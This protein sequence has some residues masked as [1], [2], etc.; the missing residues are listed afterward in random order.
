[1]RSGWIVQ[2]TRA[3]PH[4][5]ATG[6]PAILHMAMGDPRPLRQELHMWLDVAVSS[7]AIA[8]E[9]RMVSFRILLTW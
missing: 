3:H 4:M 9:S 2:F 1:M 5:R 7:C 8:H 6:C